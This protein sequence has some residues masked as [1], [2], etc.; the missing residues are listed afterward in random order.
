MKAYF[1]GIISVVFFGGMIVSI[2]RSENEGRYLRLLCGLSV[3]ASIVLPIFSFFGNADALDKDYNI[4]GEQELFDESEYAEIY[5]KT[6][7]Y[8]DEKNAEEILKS[9]IIK[10]VGAKNED[11]DVDII[12]G[13]KSGEFYIFKAVLKIR[14]SGLA[15]D[16]HRMKKYVENRLGCE[17]SIVYE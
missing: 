9:E 13:D 17:C 11:V 1:V 7:C 3:M 16:P 14:P 2:A 5:N 6:L 15:L 10:E 12:T 8:A 4:F